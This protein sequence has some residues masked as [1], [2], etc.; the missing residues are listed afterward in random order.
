M[1]GEAKHLGAF[2]KEGASKPGC[3]AS[4][5]DEVAG[6]CAR[7]DMAIDQAKELNHERAF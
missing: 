4:Q 6:R 2:D 3:F 5:N 7:L 1:L